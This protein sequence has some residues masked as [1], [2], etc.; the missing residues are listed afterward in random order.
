MNLLL[1]II[2]T[3]PIAL[4]FVLGALCGGL[5]VMTWLETKAHGR[6]SENDL[7]RWEKRQLLKILQQIH[8]NPAARQDGDG[9]SKA[10]RRG[11]S[12]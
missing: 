11:Q 4:W 9:S 5:L 8:G 2:E 1:R 10:D 7:L 3:A 6:M 12:K